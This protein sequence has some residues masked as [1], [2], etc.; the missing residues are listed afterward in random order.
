MLEAWKL[1]ADHDERKKHR[2]RLAILEFN[3]IFRETLILSITRRWF[4][5]A[6]TVSE[7]GKTILKSQGVFDIVKP[8]NRKVCKKG[9]DRITK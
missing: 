3:R 4:K 1:S 8:N 5:L 6:L 7:K 2:P 9:Q